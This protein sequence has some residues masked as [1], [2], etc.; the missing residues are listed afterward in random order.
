LGLP[1]ISQT[2]YYEA[3]KRQIARSPGASCFSQEVFMSPTIV[4]LAYGAAA[5]LALLALYFFH[6]RHWYW[7]VAS[8]LLALAIGFA[9]IPPNW[10]DPGTDLAVGMLLVFLLFWGILAP[11][12]RVPDVEHHK[13]A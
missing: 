12:F 10:N 6:A 11:L 9:P 5:M 8:V 7:H 1:T 13:H 4:S 2:S 3:G